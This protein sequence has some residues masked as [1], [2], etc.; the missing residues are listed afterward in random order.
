MAAETGAL[1]IHGLGGTEFDLGLMHKVLAAAGIETHGLT[2]PGHGT[3]PQDL[4]GVRMEDWLDAVARRYRELLP[5]YQ[6]L[7]V[8]GMCM[9]SLLALE[10]CKTEGHAQGKLV[11][12]ATPVFLDGWS[13]P[14]YRGLRHA[15]YLVPG[16]AERMRVEEEDPFGI[17]SDLVRSIVK[18]KFARGDNFHY[19]WVPLACVRQVDRLRARVM[20]G[21]GRIACPTFI[22]H[23]E[24][25]ELTSP[26]SA[27]FLA[28]EIPGSQL[29]LVDNSYHMICVD[30][31]REKVAAGVLEF[32]GKDPALARAR[33]SGRRA[34]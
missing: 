1:L 25:D 24:E 33:R 14:W 26:K 12:L 20:Q 6:T 15:L 30:N 11:A 10:L 3:Q 29:L 19:P 28:R 9:G 21:L 7:H 31:D 18:A 13:A 32:F 34:A 16:V 22:A 23:A 17:K 5:R 4:V 27:H 8:L 2:L